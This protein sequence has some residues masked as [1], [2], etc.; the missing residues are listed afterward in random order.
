MMLYYLMYT[1]VYTQ[2][3]FSKVSTASTANTT[4][5]VERRTFV[6]PAIWEKEQR[7]KANTN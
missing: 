5:Y 7:I 1:V 2:I 4:E 3:R 6:K